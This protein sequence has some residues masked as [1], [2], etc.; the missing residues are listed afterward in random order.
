MIAA[1]HTGRPR[2]EVDDRVHVRL[3]RQALLTQ[4]DPVEFWCVLDEAALRRPVGGR[5][6]M[7][8]QLEHL[9]RQAA[10]P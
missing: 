8:C 10:L 2:Q 7:R 6:V 4:D 5:E 3:G 1:V 9:V